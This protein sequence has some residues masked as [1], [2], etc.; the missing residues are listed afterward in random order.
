MYNY[1]Y[2]IYAFVKVLDKSSEI[3]CLGCHPK[4]DDAQVLSVY[5]QFP[6]LKRIQKI[7]VWVSGS[8]IDNHVFA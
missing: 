2:I 3:I 4:I 1:V 8:F 7:L 6:T 5:L